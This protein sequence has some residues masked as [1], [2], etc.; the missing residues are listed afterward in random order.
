MAFVEVV[1]LMN[2][3]CHWSVYF[4]FASLR[5]GERSPP[6]GIMASNTPGAGA[7]EGPNTVPD[8]VIVVPN[9]CRL[10]LTVK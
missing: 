9:T 8:V 7:P 10:L 5:I 4:P 3:V 2:V 6:D 1:V